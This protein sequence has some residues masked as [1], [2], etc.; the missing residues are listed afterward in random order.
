MLHRRRKRCRVRDLGGVYVYAWVL[1]EKVEFIYILTTTQTDMLSSNPLSCFPARLMGSQTPPDID[2]ALLLNPI[3]SSGKLES[4]RDRC[5]RL[6]LMHPALVVGVKGPVVW[7]KF[8]AD[9]N[10]SQRPMNEHAAIENLAAAVQPSLDTHLLNWQLRCEQLH[11]ITSSSNTQLPAWFMVFGVI[12][13]AESIVIV[14]HIPFIVSPK[15]TM[16]P[17]SVDFG[18]RFSYLSCVVDCIPFAP[19]STKAPLSQSWFRDRFR[20]ALALVSLQTQAF[21]LASLWESVVWPSELSLAEANM[22]REYRGPTPTPSDKDRAGEGWNWDEISLPELSLTRSEQQ[23][24]VDDEI[25]EMYAHAQ[26]ILPDLLR[27]VQDVADRS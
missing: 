2:F 9:P 26:E 23:A 12:Y 27:W 16:T 11:R 10:L 18:P 15:E 13:D 4:R 14:A 6:A 19:V 8:L 5:L 1:D 24:E 3:G 25:K 22:E 7:P 17:L 21:R 20:A